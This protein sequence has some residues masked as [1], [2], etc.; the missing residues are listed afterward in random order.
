M[1]KKLATVNSKFLT[2]NVL[3]VHRISLASR[4]M[5][6]KTKWPWPW[7]QWPRWNKAIPLL[8]IL[9]QRTREVLSERGDLKWSLTECETTDKADRRWH[10]RQGKKLNVP[11]KA[12]RHCLFAG[13][14]EEIEE[15]ICKTQCLGPSYTICNASIDSIRPKDPLDPSEKYAVVYKVASKQCDQAYVA[16]TEWSL[17]K[18]VEQGRSK[19]FL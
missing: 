17:R 6:K 15:N 18:R 19:V 16:E 3:L 9:K 14:T 10:A 12:L 2:A 1:E 11:P 13:L 5:A 4:D 7:K 8:K